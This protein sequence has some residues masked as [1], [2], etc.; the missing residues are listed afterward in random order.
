MQL[1]TVIASTAV[2]LGVLLVAGHA[3]GDPAAPKVATQ[4]EKAQDREAKR[5]AGIAEQ[6]KR[7][8]EFARRCIRPLDVPANL[9][10]CRTVYRQM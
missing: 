10:A 2:V 8:A 3:Q 1:S 4:H 7:K 6:E 9:E 5:R